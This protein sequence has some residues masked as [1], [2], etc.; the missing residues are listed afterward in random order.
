[1]CVKRFT[2]PND[3]HAGFLVSRG[4]RSVI[5]YRISDEEELLT[6]RITALATTYGRYGYRLITGL[7]TERRVEREPQAGGE[8]LEE[9]RIEGAEETTQT[10]KVV[11]Q[12]WFVHQAQATPQEPCLELRFCD[13][14]D[15]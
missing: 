15:P 10:G 4:Q 14:K 7:L 8:D 2:S 11:A 6:A 9:R 12:R 1:M 13:V 5:S 3:G